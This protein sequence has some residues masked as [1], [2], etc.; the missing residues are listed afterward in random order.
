MDYPDNKDQRK[1]ANAGGDP[2]KKS[3]FS[4]FFDFERKTKNY[5]NYPVF[6]KKLPYPR[7]LFLFRAKMRFFGKSCLFEIFYGII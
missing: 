3:Q 2:E 1:A 4:A 5:N 7:I 6:T